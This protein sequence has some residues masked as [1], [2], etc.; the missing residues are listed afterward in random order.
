[1]VYE[2]RRITMK[3]GRKGERRESERDRECAMKRRKK[4]NTTE[5]ITQCKAFILPTA[6]S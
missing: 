4:Q 6:I 5:E 3:R 1:M 2:K